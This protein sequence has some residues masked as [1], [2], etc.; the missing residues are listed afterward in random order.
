MRGNYGIFHFAQIE[1]TVYMK[2]TIEK[3]CVLLYISLTIKLYAFAACRLRLSCCS[4]LMFH[5]MN[6]LVGN[7]E[8]LSTLHCY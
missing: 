8:F 1:N 3:C 6:I 4:C 5:N 7:S 2:A